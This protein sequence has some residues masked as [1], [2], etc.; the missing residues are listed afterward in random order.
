MTGTQQSDR[1]RILIADDEPDMRWI[2]QELFED[3]GFIVDIARDGQEALNRLRDERPDVILT[4][5]RMPNM[6]GIDLLRESQAIDPDLPV[7]LL[8]AVEDVATA[9]DA[10]RVGAFDYQAK[11]FDEERLVLSARRAAERRSLVQEVE[12]LRSKLGSTRIRFGTS[13]LAEALDEMIDLVAPQPSVSVLVQGESGTGKEYVARAIHERSTVADGPFVAVDCGALPETLMESQLFG[14]KKGAF[15]GADR[16]EPGQFRLA[17]GGTLFLDELGNLPASLQSKLLRAVQ[18]RTVVPLGGGEPLPFQARLICATNA[19]L[20][21]AV[22]NGSFRLDLYHRIAEFVLTV[23]P[24]RTRHDDIVHFAE[25]FLAEACT[26]LGRRVTRISTDAL[27]ALRGHAW[28]GNLRELRNVIRR[29]VLQCAGS[30][31]T[32]ASLA[33]HAFT[34][35]DLP[36]DSSHSDAPSGIPNLQRIP[37][38][39]LPHPSSAREDHRP[40]AERVKA[41]ADAVEADLLR[42]ALLQSKGNKAAAARSLGIDY[43]TLHRKLKRHGLT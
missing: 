40:L 21:E 43:T 18:E 42:E 31:L 33:S 26:D 38:P 2:L 29:A 13:T 39:H 28:P 6:S 24:L 17:H 10:M 22:A 20:D 11:P 41:A 8:S 3:A 16:D 30:E 34:A 36:A 37:K 25:R 15:T 5:V 4:D 14:H 19:K 12:E 27:D 9:V 35:Q 1:A 23:E 32:R 7:I